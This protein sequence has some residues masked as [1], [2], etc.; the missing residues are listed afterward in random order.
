MSSQR[1]GGDGQRVAE[2]AL[3][4]TQASLVHKGRHTPI[5]AAGITVGRG[6]ENGLR[7]TGERV[8]RTHARVYV[9]E[10]D[11]FRVADLDSRHGTLVNGEPLQGGTRPLSSGD[12]IA[13]DEHVI[14]FLTGSETRVASGELQVM[15]TMVVPFKGGR[16]TIGRDPSNDVVLDDPNVSRFHAELIGGDD[17]VELVDLGSRNGTRVD[18]RTVERAQ[19]EPGS[20]LGIGPFR[21]V[22]EGDEVV[23]TDDRGALR[24]D[25]RGVTIEVKGK[26]ILASTSFGLEPGEFLVIIGESGAGKSTLIKTLAGVSR[27]SAGA[28]T[29]N[30]EPISSRLTDVGY[31]PQDEIVHP[32]LTVLEA[33]RYS[34]KLRL[35]P[36]LSAEEVDA[37][38]DRVL[39]E[40]SLTEHANT[41]IGSLSGGQRKRAGVAV[42][43]LGRPSLLLLDEPTTGLDPGLETKMMLLLRDLADNS[44]GVA[45]VTHATRNLELCDKVAVMGRGGELTFFG[46]PKQALDFFEVGEYDGIYGALDETPALEWRKRFEADETGQVADRERAATVAPGPEPVASDRRGVIPQALV[47]TRR[48]LKLFLRDR[49]NLALLVGQVP[50]LALANVGVFKSGLFDTPGRPTDAAQLLFLLTIVVIWLG[51]IDAAREIVKEKSVFR[52]ETAIGIHVR[53]YLISKVVVLF[54]LVAVQAVLL[55]AVVF[56][57]Q[58]LHEPVSVY[59]EVIALL[60]ATGF[61]A[62][63]MGLLVSA[64]VNTEDQAMSFTPLVLIPQLLFAGAI[65]PLRAMAEPVHTISQAMFAQ[66]SFASLGTAV[67]M[68]GRLAADPVLSRANPFGTSFFDVETLTGMAILAAF[69]AAF[70]AGTAFL[71][72]RQARSR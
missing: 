17:G 22:F 37:I 65:V 69:L 47:L 61:V 50:V 30:G 20:E 16:L 71:L 21:V 56:A 63:A 5:P 35:P 36:D 51:S 6:E 1:E 67:D 57:I 18:G 52:R 25:A 40:L 33:L 54:S 43:L 26:Q 7:L 70:A 13:I 24:L 11:R 48:Y 34:A 72:R 55:A 14:R 8:S 49:H 44:R 62:V 68:N 28:V 39:E 60:V 45:V 58:P 31:V 59:A 3:P 46:T 38:V 23:A 10:W 29:V 64:L 42:E 27:P 41:L 4:P 66:W 2:R 19:L 9:D 12:T 53:A 32:Y 15:E